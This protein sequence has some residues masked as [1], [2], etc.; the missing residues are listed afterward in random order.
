MHFEG[1]GAGTFVAV[2][3]HAE[4]V[5]QGR[6]RGLHAFHRIQKRIDSQVRRSGFGGWEIAIKYHT[7]S[8]KRV[9]AMRVGWVRQ[10]DLDRPELDHD[11][12]MSQFDDDELTIVMNVLFLMSSVSWK[13]A[14]VSPS[15]AH[16]SSEVLELGWRRWG[17]G[18]GLETPELPGSLAL[19]LALTTACRVLNRST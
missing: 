14:P 5:K 7:T 6:E 16:Q 18:E 15:K 13:E 4:A 8:T 3:E 2:C 1:G 17:R 12:H 9:L 10:N 19:S 11:H